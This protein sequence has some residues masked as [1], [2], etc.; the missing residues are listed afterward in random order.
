M[1]HVP[2]GGSSRASPTRSP[3][4]QDPQ[5]RSFPAAGRLLQEATAACECESCVQNVGGGYCKGDE[6]T[7]H[8]CVG[9]G[10]VCSCYVP[11][12]CATCVR[13]GGEQPYCESIWG[14]CSC[15]IDGDGDGDGAQDGKGGAPAADACADLSSRTEAVNDEC[16]NEP[17]EDCSSGRP[18]TCNPGCAHVLLPFFSDCSD[19]LGAAGAASFD[20]VVRLC[21]AATCPVGGFLSGD[22]HKCTACPVGFFKA[23]EGVQEC[24][25][26][27]AGTTTVA[28]GSTLPSQCVPPPP[29]PPEPTAAVTCAPIIGMFT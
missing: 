20:D 27:L 18:S 28:T 5:P 29:P 23:E 3:S 9:L 11:C 22:T 4:R 1:Q 14:D 7:I 8:H 19:A 2:A 10:L 15:L 25:E 6:C 21:R 13:K 24:T 26:C 17:T 16:C 12:P